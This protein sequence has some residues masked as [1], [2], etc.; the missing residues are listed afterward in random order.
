VRT[1]PVNPDVN[2]IADR[3]KYWHA[4]SAE[5]SPNPLSDIAYPDLHEITAGANHAHTKDTQ[6]PTAVQDP[7][8]ELSSTRYPDP[9]SRR[10]C[11]LASA[12]FQNRKDNAHASIQLD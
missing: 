7:L 1:P 8:G 9:T 3:A 5:M 10:S 4:R 6:V 11:S 2:G 12:L